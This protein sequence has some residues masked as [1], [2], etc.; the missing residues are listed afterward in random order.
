MIM[1]SVL[2]IKGN[3]M[4][5]F[6]E[7]EEYQSRTDHGKRGHNCQSLGVRYSTI[8]VV[9]VMTSGSTC[10]QHAKGGCSNMARHRGMCY[11][12]LSVNIQVL[13]HMTCCVYYL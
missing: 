11:D 10:M 12:T 7:L 9:F 2:C 5:N 3:N 8:V 4:W 6:L 1:N 13:M